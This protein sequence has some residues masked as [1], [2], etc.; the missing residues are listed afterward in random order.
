MAI[1]TAY[2]SWITAIGNLV[3]SPRHGGRALSYKIMSLTHLKHTVQLPFIWGLRQGIGVMVPL[4][5]SVICILMTVF[6]DKIIIFLPPPFS[7]CSLVK[8]QCDMWARYSLPCW[9]PVIR[10]QAGHYL[11]DGK[12]IFSLLHFL[13]MK[14][15]PVP[16]LHNCSFNFSVLIACPGSALLTPHTAWWSSWSRGNISS[17]LKVSITLNGLYSDWN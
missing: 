3:T 9:F 17:R 16:A 5:T 13:R 11:D 4:N 10:E 14:I 15:A 12:W 7:L 6:K 2:K 8:W 1:Y